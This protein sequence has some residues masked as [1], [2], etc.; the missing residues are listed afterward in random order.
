MTFRLSRVVTSKVYQSIGIKSTLYRGFVVSSRPRLSSSPDKETNTTISSISNDAVAANSATSS[1]DIVIN[2]VTHGDVI[3]EKVVKTLTNHPIDLVMSLIDY[4]HTTVDIPYWGAIIG[5]TIA[6]RL[7][8]VPVAVRQQRNAVRMRALSPD[9]KKLQHL[10]NTNP[11][12]SLRYAAEMKQL[13]KHYDVNPVRVFMVPFFQAPVFICFFMA[14]RQMGDYFPAY[15]TGGTAWFTD[16]TMSD[17]TFA[18]PVLNA[19]SFLA[20][21][22]TGGDD[23][24]QN[25]PQLKTVLRVMALGFIPIM[26]Y[27]PQVCT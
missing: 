16:L 27:M 6:V 12:D 5:C 17:P 8:L 2:A 18:L 10:A 1:N 15:A 22:E 21:L 7:L 24:N 26:A 4:V 23:L 14:L 13:M 11:S 20:I 3:A 19:L 9:L 25:N